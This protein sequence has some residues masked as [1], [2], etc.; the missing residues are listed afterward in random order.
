MYLAVVGTGYV[1]LVAAAC[2]ADS[3]NH[4][5][6]VDSD[7]Q[8]IAQLKQGYS[9]IYEPGLEELLERN[10]KEG[11]LHFTTDL[12]QAVQDSEILFI[13]VGTPSNSNGSV[14]LSQVFAVAEEIA[15]TM[16]GPKIIVLKSTVP[17]G[18]A[19]QVRHLIA[20]HTR[21]EFEIVSNPEFLKEGAALNDFLKPDRV[22]IGTNSLKAAE[23]MKELYAPFVRTEKPIIVMDNRSAE[24]TKYAANLI[25]ATK[26]SV[27][28][29]LANLCEHVGADIEQVRKGVGAD[30]RIGYAFIFPGVGYGGS[31]FPKDVKA[32]IWVGQ[33]HGYPLRIAAAVDLINNEQR[34]RFFQKIYNHFQGHLEGRRITIWGLTF[35]PGTDDMREAP[36]ITIIEKLLEHGASVIAHDPK[37]N[38]K[39]HALFGD[40]IEYSDDHYGSVQA[41]E[42]LVVLT[43]WGEFRT[44]D[45][46]RIK[47]EMKTPVIFDGRNIYNP[48]KLRKL[49]FTYYGVGR[50]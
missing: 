42:A 18:T 15:R 3:G 21:Y 39:A 6:G 24:M 44:P 28:N 26:I 47:R 19:D 12:A 46:E 49:G 17:V 9:P 34:L 22:I 36:S 50:P 27:M 25:L 23:V 31:C 33:A 48:E 41:A 45:F 29:E 10:M 35:K 4:V 1:G 40:R 20:Q 2:F 38:S 7:P 11:R 5:I 43:E 14:D 13:A 32:L 30:S 16:N 37:A 8:K